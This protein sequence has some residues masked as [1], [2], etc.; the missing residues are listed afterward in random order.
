MQQY[1]VS[2][3]E[4]CNKIKEMVEIEWMNINQEIQDPSHPPL[5]WL[6]PPLNLARMMVVLYQNGD[7]YTN[8]SGKTKDRIASLLVDP[9]PM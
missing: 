9:V 8:S 1:G 5:Q 3:E 7:G 2:E 4:A 6:L